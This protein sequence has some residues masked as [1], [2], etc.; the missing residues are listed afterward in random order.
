MT[1]TLDLKG[2]DKI[3][4]D[5]AVKHLWQTILEDRDQSGTISLDRRHGKVFLRTKIHEEVCNLGNRQE[6]RRN[7][8]A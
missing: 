4:E 8:P 5:K 6:A 1:G 7:V 2:A 3:S